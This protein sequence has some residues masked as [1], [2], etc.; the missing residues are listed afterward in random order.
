MSKKEISSGTQKAESL[1][2]NGS[3]KSVTKKPAEK[4]AKP[5]KQVNTEK[6]VKPV[7]EKPAEKNIKHGKNKVVKSE[8]KKQVSLKRQQKRTAR[9][10][11]KLEA[12]KIRAEKK[13]RRLEKKLE[14]KQKRLDR[15][16]AMKQAR[17][18]RKEK[19][20]ERRDMLKHET[21]EARL[22]RRAEERHAKMEARV[23][24]RQAAAAEKQAKREH[25]LK[26]RAER[27][28]EK[29]E[30]QRAPGF[31]GWLAAVI[32]LG[33]TTL[34]LGTMLTFGW[35]NMNGM[36]ADMAG[37]HTESVYELNS[38]VD[39][40]DA[41]LSKARVSN[42]KNEQVKLLSD[43]AIESEMAETV[44][45]RLPVDTQ[46][47]QNM[48]SFV[49][50]MGDSA[51]SMLYAVAS[52]KKL[53]ESQIAT[54]E[55]MYST[56]KQFKSAINELCANCNGGDVLAAMRGKTDGIFYV[57]FDEI[58]NNTIET[59]KEINDGPFAENVKKAT[60]KNLDKLEE[61][62][63]A[64]AEK[65]AK[66]YFED[67]GV[68]EANC[69]G[70]VVAEQLTCYNVS[71]TTKDGEMSAQISKRGGKVVEFNSYKDCSD[72]NFSVERCI[73]IAE[74]FLEDLG[75]DDMKAVWTSENGTTCNLNFVYEDD[76]VVF[77]SDMIKV[78]VCE[79]R[80]IVTGVEALS[81]VLNHVKR[82]TPDA[83]ISKS[84]AK[85]KLHGGFD[86][87][88]SRLCVIPTANGEVL[89]Y[90]FCGEYEGNT[91]YVYIDAN[92]GD[93]VEVFTVVGTA[94]GKALL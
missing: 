20:R 64:Q 7:A 78:K 21:K 3:K 58:E 31:G 60:A 71:L 37:V 89:C 4:P 48:T 70:E 66:K 18:E 65:L 77:Y 23:A 12:A 63:E 59:P 55:H 35:I 53:T 22:E 40:L 25:R 52:G 42:S 2:D 41:N 49:N 19:R 62:N 29:S 16:A 54:L 27:R 13:Q 38:I 86:V 30:K 9:E 74:D 11:K 34:A 90:E 75:Y 51:Q 80:G 8:K 84:E 50:K 24:K 57:T 69:T 15:I 6:K 67:Y 92:T 32:S 10:Q 5:V 28:A 87:E 93:E 88:T 39:N 45:E 14:A 76:D 17:A 82:D 81:Y 85:A 46:L 72:K 56:N 26:L 47:T 79:E 73:D 36:Q 1:A 43:I 68:T 91:Y 33:V 83:G 61:I 94:Q 44:L